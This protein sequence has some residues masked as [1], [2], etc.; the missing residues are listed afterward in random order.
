MMRENIV[1]WLKQF[2]LAADANARWKCRQSKQQYQALT[3]RYAAP[4]VLTEPQQGKRPHVLYVGTDK[5]QDYSG[6]IQALQRVA[7]VTIFE[8]EPGVYG[9]LWPRIRAAADSVRTH[10]GERLLHYVQPGEGRGIDLVIGQMWG[11]SMH[12]RAL[13]QVR[14]RN[15]PIVNIGMDD[16]HAFVGWQ[17]PD[18]AQGGTQGLIPYLSLSCTAAPE[19]VKWYEAE[20]GAAIFWPEASDPSVFSAPTAT[21]EHD[22]CFVG[23]NYGIRAEMVQM[24]ERAGIAV[25]TYGAGWSNGRI[26]VEE[27]PKLFAASKIILGCGTIGYCRDFFALKMRDFDAAMAGSMYVTHANPDFAPLLREGVEIV[28][29]KELPQLVEIVRHYLQAE[30]ERE[31]IA[32]AGA[33]RARREHTWDARFAL[34]LHS[35]YTLPGVSITKREN[36]A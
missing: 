9:Q 8:Q 22:V 12:W 28:T 35:L 32:A 10:N 36:H 25:R 21:K 17:L 5:Q 23:A 7:D 19:C 6:I 1:A 11:L 4:S 20:G 33:V 34:M 27:M 24:L 18:G 14:E 15:I 30:T 2:P 29:F 26:S 16:R 3:R 31:Q 13:A